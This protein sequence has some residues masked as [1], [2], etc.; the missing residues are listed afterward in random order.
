MLRRFRV[1]LQ[2]VKFKIVIDCNSLTLT[3]NKRKINPQIVRWALE[4]LSYNYELEHRPGSRIKHV[5]AL[6]RT[7]GIV[8]EKPFEW[9]LTQG[10]DPKIVE[11][12]DQLEKSENKFF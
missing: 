9:N 7:V 4:L 12:R 2:N 8:D 1:N 10:Q 11:V 3:L 6:S 5:D